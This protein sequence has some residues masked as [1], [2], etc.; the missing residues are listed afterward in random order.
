MTKHTVD[1]YPVVCNVITILYYW[2][3]TAVYV[4]VLAVSS[5]LVWFYV[6]YCVLS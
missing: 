3:T 2:R 1:K 5:Q 6:C 4:D